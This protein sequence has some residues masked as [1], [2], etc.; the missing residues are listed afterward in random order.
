MCNFATT[1]GFI[2]LICSLLIPFYYES[3]DLEHL[4]F[5]LIH[6]FLSLKYRMKSDVDRPM[7]SSDYRAFEQIILMK[8]LGNLAEPIDPEDFIGSLRLGFNR[9]S[10]LVPKSS[11]C[12][13]R[14]GSFEYDQH[15][16]ETYSIDDHQKPIDQFK[17]PLIIYLHGGGYIVGD[18]HS[19]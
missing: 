13:I 12:Q 18:I 2:L 5:R 15:Q 19:H 1:V 4:R 14:H 17:D 3:I 11:T 16:V 6:S 10:S 9:M 8:P 7:L